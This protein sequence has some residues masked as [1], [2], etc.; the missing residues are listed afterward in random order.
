MNELPVGKIT[1]KGENME[2]LIK[3]MEILMK[4]NEILMKKVEEL[5][6]NQISE[7]K[8]EHMFNKILSYKNNEVIKPITPRPRS[9]VKNNTTDEIMETFTHYIDE[10]ETFNQ[11]VSNVLYTKNKKMEY[12]N[13]VI[14]EIE[15]VNGGNYANIKIVNL[16][17][18]LDKENWESKIPN[19]VFQFVKY[20]KTIEDFIFVEK[21]PGIMNNSYNVY[22]YM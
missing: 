10:F 6:R 4:Q 22:I 15:K 12:F 3:N 21:T 18:L 13:K 8:L 14:S 9:P 5:E 11:Q 20:A 16:K 7:I 1:K 17:N 19:N 2:S